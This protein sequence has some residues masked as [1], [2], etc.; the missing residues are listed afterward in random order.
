MNRRTLPSFAFVTPNNVDNGHDSGSG[1]PALDRFLS[2]FVSMVQLTN[3][4]QEGTVAMFITVD[5]GSGGT[6]GQDC[7][8][9][10]LDLAGKQESCHVPFFVLDP[11]TKPGPVSGFFDH[12][13]VTRTV[14]ELFKLPLLAG[15]ANA[16][17]LVTPF[18]L[19]A[20]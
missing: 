12:Y 18:G 8:N 7:T 14:E 10:S 3:A 2:K 9:V 15:A 16:P 20:A 19:V 4:Y 1:V 5:E 6:Q 11:Y 13:S 17:S